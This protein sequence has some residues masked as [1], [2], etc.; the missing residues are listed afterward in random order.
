MIKFTIMNV[1]NSPGKMTFSFLMV[2]FTTIIVYL[3]IFCFWKKTYNWKDRN[4]VYGEDAQYGDFHKYSIL[5]R[6]IPKNLNP[7][8][9][10][11]SIKRIL[12]R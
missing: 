2:I 3:Q 7:S 5:I 1:E 11:E 12:N 9:A 6:G 4:F 8:E 10:G